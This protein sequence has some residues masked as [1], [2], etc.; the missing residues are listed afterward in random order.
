ML[1][2]V[3][4][5]AVVVVAIVVVFSV[6]LFFL[7]VCR[8]SNECEFLST[9]IRRRRKNRDISSESPEASDIHAPPIT[10]HMLTTPVT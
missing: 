10:A 3:V 5:V 9:V 7:S 4:V 2:L 8:V 1:L 6:C